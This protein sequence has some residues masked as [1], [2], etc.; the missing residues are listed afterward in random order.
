VLS[1][2]EAEGAFKSLGKNARGDIDFNAHFVKLA[3]S[4]GGTITFEGK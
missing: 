2:D 4:S 1:I 3:K